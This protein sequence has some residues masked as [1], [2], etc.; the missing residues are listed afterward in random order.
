MTRV[1]APAASACPTARIESP[2]MRMSAPRSALLVG[3][4]LD[5]EAV[6]QEQRA[7]FTFSPYMARV[8]RPI[9]ATVARAAS[10]CP[11]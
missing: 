7:H 2:S 1:P 8:L 10:A 9:M 5:E 3:G 4:R 6:L 11:S